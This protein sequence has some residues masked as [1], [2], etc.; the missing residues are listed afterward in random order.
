MF[1]I[2]SKGATMEGPPRRQRGAGDTIETR[3]I[4][5]R[6][7]SLCSLE[8]WC[9]FSK[10]CFSQKSLVRFVLLWAA[11]FVCFEAYFF[12]DA[13]AKLDEQLL[14][15]ELTES[16]RSVAMSG[17]I[18]RIQTEQE[19]GYK[20]HLVAGDGDA[21][22][23][24][25]NVARMT[26]RRLLGSINEKRHHHS[27]SDSIAKPDP[28]AKVMRRPHGATARLDGHEKR[29]ARRTERRVRRAPGGGGL[30][31]NNVLRNRQG[32]DV[33]PVGPA[34]IDGIPTNSYPYRDAT[35]SDP[36]TLTAIVMDPR[37]P[38][39]KPEHSLWA[40]LES[41]LVHAP[42]GACVL[43]QTSAC[44]LAGV[45][46]E[47]DAE[48]GARA[49]FR[50]IVARTP[51]PRVREFLE[52]SG[53]V[54][55]AVL[56]HRKYRLRACDN[57]LSPNKAWMNVH[58]WRDEF[59]EAVDNDMM[60]VLQSDSVLCSDL[61]IELWRE[62]AYVGAPWKNDYQAK[63][64]AGICGGLEQMWGNWT[65]HSDVHPS[66][67]MCHGGFGPQGNGGLS[68][69][70]R[71]WMIKAIEACP[72]SYSG[73]SHDTVNASPCRVKRNVKHSTT[74]PAEDQYFG[75]VLRGLGA[76]MP[77]AFEAALFASEMVFP[78][79]E[80]RDWHGPRDASRRRE[81]VGRRLG[82]VGLA[83]YEA[84]SKDATAVHF[85]PIGLHK[86]WWYHE[87][88]FFLDPGLH[89]QCPYLKYIIPLH[90]IH[91][92]YRDRAK[93]LGFVGYHDDKKRKKERFSDFRR[94]RVPV[95]RKR[96]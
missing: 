37:L 89:Q 46:A 34:K 74:F 13:V 84:F 41:F 14:R 95:E 42:P 11:G 3:R 22:A 86:V 6:R 91:E 24:Q 43:L 15:L 88:S 64:E 71:K 78:D 30:A 66:L 83:H 76:P 31:L 60:L 51:R 70:S 68:L 48:S 81:L 12:H 19:Q 59:I 92:E 40:A 90:E 65:K 54:R 50:E 23:A 52:G 73:L 49:A 80:A 28:S 33:E 79:T 53:R 9:E 67:D 62:F 26:V 32:G 17:D 4:K 16:K 5:R 72:S 18:P 47:A 63:S 20:Y 56:D 8:F 29:G 57:F 96:H 35:P 10:E 85:L 38:T 58:Y 39:M 77:L 93:S 94:H 44:G 21:S 87:Q 36:C 75:T 69:R 82:A 55:A 27:L 7:S 61:D 45:D 25:R 1:Q 2:A